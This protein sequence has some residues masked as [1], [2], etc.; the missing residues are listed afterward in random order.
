MKL[1]KSK[2]WLCLLLV[3]L[4]AFF[5]SCKESDDEEETVAL[6]LNAY[7]VTMDV[8]ETFALQTGAENA[9]FTSENESVAKVDDKGRVLGVAAG[10]TKIV[11]T[12]G[13][14]EAECA[15]TIKS[16]ARPVSYA[17][18]MNETQAV[19]KIGESLQ[20][21]ASV[22][23]NGEATTETATFSST[24]QTV[25]NVDENGKITAISAGETTIQATYGEAQAS[26]RVFVSDTVLRLVLNETSAVIDCG[27]TLRLQ[28][29]LYKDGEVVQG[30]VSYSSNNGNVAVT[31]SG[32]IT[33][34]FCGESVVTVTSGTA[35]AY[36]Q[37]RVE[38]EKTIATV[39]DFT[40]IV[41]DPY[42][43]YTLANDIDFADYEWNT[44]TIVRKLS[45]VFNGNGHKL[46]NLSR[47]TGGSYT[48]IFG[49][50]TE[51]ATLKDVA[52][53]V[54]AY[55][56]KSN[57]G[58]LA[59][60]NRGV[61]EN[62][63]IKAACTATDT[64]TATLLQSGLVKENYGSISN[65]LVE[66][67]VKAGSNATGRFH[68]LAAKNLGTI[69]D[70]IVVS[71]GKINYDVEDADGNKI[72][73]T[74]Y[75]L[76]S[77]PSK[78]YIKTTAANTHNALDENRRNCVI[79]ENAENLLAYFNGGY[80]I[81]GKVGYV[82]DESEARITETTVFDSFAKSAWTFSAT[83]ITFFGTPLY[84]A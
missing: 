15:F 37:I 34:T 39:E 7:S 33:G 57:C 51:T 10:E 30:D 5:V 73:Y 84:T 25:A 24:E 6:A 36:C 71:S 23:K 67:S 55:Y 66:V 76:L 8:G 40:S 46:F 56:Y 52:V 42:V 18:Q 54:D 83:E 58:V 20:L 59:Y 13:E 70:C 4:F 9:T 41:D 79:F 17:V 29:T 60:T 69:E 45:S 62:C 65:L 43:R 35:S 77:C 49:E 32:E 48:A 38:R 81:D 68:A 3:L 22:L 63:Y 1:L 28:A 53:Y 61:I 27:Q 78:G 47:K 19:L 26:C 11:V 31:D 64:A 50:L 14:E 44:S 80:A 72:T 74:S 2:N 75:Q 16:I 82:T 21:T 12:N